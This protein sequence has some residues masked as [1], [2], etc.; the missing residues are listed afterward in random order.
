MNENRQVRDLERDLLGAFVVFSDDLG[1]Y[2]HT[3]EIL[4]FLD[5]DDFARIENKVIF[6]AVKEIASTGA[7]VTDLAIMAALS[8]KPCFNGPDGN[9]KIDSFLDYAKQTS[10]LT[11]WSLAKALR[12]KRFVR[13]VERRYGLFC[14]AV[15]SS[16]SSPFDEFRTHLYPVINIPSDTDGDETVCAADYVVDMLNARTISEKPISTGFMHLDSVLK[17]GFKREWLVVIGARPAV[18]KTTFAINLISYAL[19]QQVGRI[20][21]FTLEMSPGEIAEKIISLRTNTATDHRGRLPDNEAVRTAQKNLRNEPLLM[22]SAVKNVENLVH[23]A[24]QIHEQEP[25]AL[26]VI[27]YLQFIPQSDPRATR[28]S[29]V[30]EISVALKKLAQKTGVPVIALSQL[31]R[32]A[33]QA[34]ETHPTLKD[35]RESG[36]IEQD[37]NVVM[38]LSRNPKENQAETE[39]SGIREIFVNVA[40]NRHGSIGATTL[41]FHG[42]TSRFAE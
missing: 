7:S 31:S 38:L 22:C 23:K 24:K 5:E 12:K 41:R 36:Q 42:A 14:H 25:L 28:F 11:A 39:I 20:L 17:G 8:N 26:I 29:A 10:S 37:A 9:A 40:K 4:A 18:G 13:E 1:N 19:R 21:F 33:G 2:K 35:L 3:A 6:T 15:K 32:P 34:E 30:T 16:D 27:D